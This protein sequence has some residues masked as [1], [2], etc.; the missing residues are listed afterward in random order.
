MAYLAFEQVVADASVDSITELTVPNNAT[1][2][3]LQASVNH[4]SYTMDGST[5]PT[6]TAGMFLLTT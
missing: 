2:A 1:H 5:D 4:V 6:Q 3:E